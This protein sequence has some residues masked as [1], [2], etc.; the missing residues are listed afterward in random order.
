MKGG[1]I[2]KYFMYLSHKMF[3]KKR[4]KFLLK[5]F[6][7]EENFYI[8]LLSF[9]LSF[10]MFTY[11]NEFVYNIIPESN[12]RISSFE[13]KIGKSSI[14]ILEDDSS[15]KKSY[16]IDKVFFENKKIKQNETVLHYIKKG[17]YGYTLEAIYLDSLDNVVQINIKK[18]PNS[19]IK[20]YN[21]GNSKKILIEYGTKREILN[22]ENYKEG[23]FIN[24][25]P[26]KKSK[27]FLIYSI[28]SYMVS[29]ILIFGII[30]KLKKIKIKI[31]KFFNEYYPKRMSFIFFVIIIIFVYILIFTDSLPKRLF[32]EKGYLFGDQGY[33]WKIAELF[34][35]KDFVSLKNEIFTFRGYMSSL[36]PLISQFIG[37]LINLNPL[38]I[39]YVI[40]IALISIFIG[41]TIPEIFFSLT[42]NKPKNYQIIFFFIIF[43]IFWKSMYYSVLTDILALIF[44]S[45]FLLILIK[46]IKSGI[47]S[48]KDTSFLLGILIYISI[49]YRTNY[50]Y[51]VYFILMFFIYNIIVKKFFKKEI[52]KIK[53]EYICFFLIGI[54]LASIPQIIINYYTQRHIGI[55]PYAN[56][57][58]INGITIE[59]NLINLAL[60]DCFI[61]WPYP[62]SDITAKQ[63]LMNA[64]NGESYLSVIQALSAYI[65]N[66]LDSLIIMIKKMI[67]SLNIKLSEVYPDFDYSKNT[68]FYLFS[69][70]NYTI[71]STGL[72]LALSQKKIKDKIFK[73]GEIILG[74]ILIILFIFPQLIILADARYFILLYIIIYY[75][76]SFKFFEF[77]KSKNFHINSYLKF[78]CISI[79]FFYLINSYYY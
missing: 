12:I 38:Y 59:E 71:V 49:S 77:M 56:G 74:R 36:F 1:C 45:F 70:F 60:N 73:K 48:R 24:F 10:C 8:V 54:F 46:E 23:E 65:K 3:M 68:N 66:P 7:K 69:F 52:L 41:Y 22:L 42:S 78:I 27:L 50:K 34:K 19:K 62:R 20:F 76:V 47:M 16:E 25:Q 33:Y 51:G 13:K 58:Y 35:N 72:Y 15:Q 29:G 18:I 64:D 53:L 61:C 75:M 28:M 6:I 5:N 31:P 9:L 40:N 17:D 43:S 67:L 2:D 21:V 55:F 57:R 30:N 32:D 37:G 26:F 14:I 44:L 39:Y 63:I 79:L 4:V 11:I